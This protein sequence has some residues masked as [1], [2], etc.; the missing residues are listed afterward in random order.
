MH[1]F[2]AKLPRQALTE[3]SF[4]EFA[5]RE[6]RELGGSFHRG[7]GAGEDQAWWMRGLLCGIEEQRE[8]G[9]GEEECA[10]SV[11]HQEHLISPSPA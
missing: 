3:R 5:R 2:G 7:R 1:S 10:P 9:L 6:C 8:D 4:G 11:S